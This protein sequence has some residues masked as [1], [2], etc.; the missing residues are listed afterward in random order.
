MIA[1]LTSGVVGVFFSVLE[2]KDGYDTNYY[3]PVIRMLSDIGR[4]SFK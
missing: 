3:V 4:M 1:D 2:D